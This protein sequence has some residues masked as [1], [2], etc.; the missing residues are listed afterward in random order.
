MKKY[1]GIIFVLCVFILPVFVFAQGGAPT[2]SEGGGGILNDICINGDKCNFE[3]L[4][5]LITN[6]INFLIYLS[7]PIAAI[8][9]AWAGWIL[10]TSG[11][12]ESKKEQAKE[13]FTKVAIG[14]IFVLSAWLIVRFITTAL[15]NPASYEDLLNSNGSAVVVY[16]TANKELI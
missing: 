10:V 13:I 11:G 1:L 4:M 3:D 16:F 15:L 2:V 7:I 9:F 8:A 14:F 5:R 6:V 12:S